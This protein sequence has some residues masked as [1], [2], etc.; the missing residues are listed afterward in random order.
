[1]QPEN[2][3]PNRHH[4]AHG[5][6]PFSARPVIVFLTVCTRHRQPWLATPENHERI[7]SVWRRATAWRVGPYVLMPDHLHL[8]TAPGD[9]DVDFE[10]WVKFWKS[11][12]SKMHGNP[13]HRWQTDHWDR[14]LRTNESYNE[15]AA[16]MWANPV[17]HGLVA[18]PEDWPYRG[19]L[20]PLEW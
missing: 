19:E 1:M 6:R 16:Y 20:F 14:R 4:P 15:K 9:A 2:T 5:V 12:F 7:A 18:R 10:R 8:F 11:Q 17:R 13:Q 3:H